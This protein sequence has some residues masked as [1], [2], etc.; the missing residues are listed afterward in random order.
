MTSRPTRPLTLLAAILTLAPAAAVAC[1]D[2]TP[3]Q[4]EVTVA[5][6]G[7]FDHSHAALTDLLA[8]YVSDG[9]VDYGRWKADGTGPLDSYL[10]TL[11]AVSRA[12]YDGW[13]GDQQLAYWIN[14]YNAYMARK[15]LDHYP[16]GSVKNI[17]AADF[18]IFKKRFIPSPRLEGRELSLDAVEHEIIRK[19]FGDARIHF[20]LVCAA[21]SCPE[22]REEAFRA[23]DLD[24][25]LDD[26]GR[27]FLGDHEKNRYNAGTGKIYLSKIFEWF[28]G[29][30]KKSAGSVKKFVEPYLPDDARAALA[31]G[32]R[33][34][35]LK[36]DWSLNDR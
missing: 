10:E 16:L 17:G 9:L 34:G 31:A 13:T 3:A 29:D 20:A 35:F 22:L 15:V 12:D 21:S 8:K 2:K 14:T 7:G 24:A 19:R 6:E 30:F 26:Q 33:I 32:A 18:S 4:K 28:R 1:G 27:R 11:A 25:Q 23:A 5:S 36:Y